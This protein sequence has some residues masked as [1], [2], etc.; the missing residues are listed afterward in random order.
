MNQQVNSIALHYLSTAPRF[1][2]F[3]STYRFCNVHM[4]HAS[5]CWHVLAY[6]C[7]CSILQARPTCAVSQACI[8]LGGWGTANSLQAD[9]VQPENCFS[10]CVQ[11]AHSVLMRRGIEVQKSGGAPFPF[12]F[13]SWE[14]FPVPSGPRRLSL[15][16][17]WLKLNLRGNSSDFEVTWK[18][19]SK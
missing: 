19:K 5:R 8:C 7:I 18:V 12:P 3:H 1:V 13:W 4:H 9:T 15:S 17:R 2:D 10:V 11:A 6:A 16:P 14:A